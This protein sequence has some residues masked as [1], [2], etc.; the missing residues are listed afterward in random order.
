MQIILHKSVGDSLECSPDVEA[1][2][3]VRRFS[4][5]WL[6]SLIKGWRYPQTDL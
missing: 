6:W 4:F 3:G 1:V 5:R 2:G